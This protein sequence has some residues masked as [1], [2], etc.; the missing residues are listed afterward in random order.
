VRRFI[1]TRA[2]RD[3]AGVVS[4][5]SADHVAVFVKIVVAKIMQRILTLDVPAPREEN[6]S[7]NWDFSPSFK[8]DVLFMGFVFFP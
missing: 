7:P 1:R 3:R 2:E 4:S 8:W 5:S 6:W